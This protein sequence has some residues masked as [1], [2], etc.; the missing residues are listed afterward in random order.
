MCLTG[1]VVKAWSVTQDVAGS[2]PFNEKYLLSLNSVKTFR[3]NP[4]SLLV[5]R[6]SSREPPIRFVNGF[7][8]V[9]ELVH[10]HRD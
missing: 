4:K 9:R 5:A 3:N 7:L 8:D 2:N 1:P 6:Q 10:S